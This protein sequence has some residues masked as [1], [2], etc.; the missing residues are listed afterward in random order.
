MRTAAYLE[1]TEGRGRRRL[2]KLELRAELD[3]LEHRTREPSLNLAERQEL[4]DLRNRY[5][6][7]PDP[8]NRRAQSNKEVAERMERALQ[9]TGISEDV[10]DAM[11]AQWIAFVLKHRYGY[12][13]A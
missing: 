4:D 1:S 11:D 6:P 9:R 10:K 5:P 12:Q 2:D 8:N 13:R 7:L 3:E